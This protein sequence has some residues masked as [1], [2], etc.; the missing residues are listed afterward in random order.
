MYLY[1]PESKGKNSLSK[2]FKRWNLK[3]LNRVG[4][5]IKLNLKC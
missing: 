2:K 1:L 4:K 3:N 5:T